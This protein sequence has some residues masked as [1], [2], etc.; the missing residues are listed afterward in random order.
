MHFKH[1]LLFGCF[2]HGKL[3]QASSS[4]GTFQESSD[5]CIDLSVKTAPI[6][7]RSITVGSNSSGGT[8]TAYSIL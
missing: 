7:T 2:L 5:I 3:H 6:S 1:S 8:V 4:V